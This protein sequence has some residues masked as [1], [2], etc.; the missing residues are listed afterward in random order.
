MSNGTG[1]A[2]AINR[3]D[4]WGIPDPG[5]IGRFQFTGHAWL[6]EAGLY[7]ARAGIYSPT[8]G[9]F[10]QTDPIGYADGMNL[11]NYVGSDPINGVDPTGTCGLFNG[12]D[13]LN[14]KSLPA[15]CKPDIVVNGL[16]LFY[17][18]T[19]LP[20]PL[21]LGS[22]TA[23]PP[24]VPGFGSASVAAIAGKDK[25]QKPP[26]C[27]RAQRGLQKLGRYGVKLGGDVTTAGLVIT[28]GG[29]AVAGVSASTVVLAPGGVLLGGSIATGGAN[30]AAGGGLIGTGG[31]LLMLAGGSGKAAVSDL[32]SRVVSSRIP[33]SFGGEIISELFGQAVDAIPFEFKICK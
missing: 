33:K 32:A 27:N 10:L 25:P 12:S 22:H 13:N 29:L 7:Y 24:L 14:G 16:R 8:L 19:T 31:A 26:P 6:P 20:F 4:D 9:R 17:F 15:N 2:L 28:G 23:I 21:A 30:V 1:N 18:P 11:Y 5:N 3:Y